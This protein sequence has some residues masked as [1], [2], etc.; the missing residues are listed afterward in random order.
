MKKKI[1]VS[2][3]L[4]IVCFVFVFSGC[5]EK[6][7]TYEFSSDFKNIAVGFAG[8][9]ATSRAFSFTTLDK[10]YENKCVV[11]L[12]PARAEE[13]SPVFN[14]K[15]NIRLQAESMKF[16]LQGAAISHNAS[17]TEL[18][19]ATK[20]FYRVGCPDKE[21]WSAW[22][23]FV[24]DDGDDVFSFIH[25]TDSQASS[26]EEYLNF[27]LTL[28]KAFSENPDIE[29]ILSTGDQV[30]LFGQYYWNKFFESIGDILRTTTFAAVNGNHEMRNE[31]ML[32]NFYTPTHGEKYTYAYE[33]GDCLFM[34]IDTNIMS[35]DPTLYDPQL[36]FFAEV[37]E[38]SDK[39]WRILA[40]HKSAYSTGT[41]ADDFDILCFKEAIT[42]FAA[43]HSI[44]L[45][46]GGHDHLY[47]RSYPI[48]GNGERVS[49]QK[50]EYKQINGYNA[51]SL[52]NPEG[53]IYVENRCAGSKFYNKT[54]SLND[55]L[56]EKADLQ[57]ISIPI[58]SILKID[59]N[60]LTYTSYEHD[61][62]TDSVTVYD[63]FE[64]IKE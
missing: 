41:H 47:C 25:I 60:T 55:H 10:S 20:Y 34:V 19:P 15:D 54:K 4:I 46:L 18:T 45:V 2:V 38:N 30:E 59:G 37:M 61:R 6:P 42:P 33:Y 49:A 28:N 32:F 8:S 29:F 7:Y 44:D 5:A 9:G 31:S 1:F 13:Q 43:E 21:A 39:K 51:T 57:K 14:G 40:G 11:Q 3:A 53:V 36:E 23:Y 62:D 22:G 12:D 58:Y 35:A 17:T 48:D 56:L 26:E 27:A 52:V 64:I 63:C 50:V 24:T 16:F